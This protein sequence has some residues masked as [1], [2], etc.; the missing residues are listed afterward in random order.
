VGVTPWPA[1]AKGGGETPETLARDKVREPAARTVARG[2]EWRMRAEGRGRAD[3]GRPPGC[4]GRAGIRTA[5]T[6]VACPCARV[7][8]GSR[9][10]AAWRAFGLAPWCIYRELGDGEGLSGSR[11]HQASGLSSPVGQVAVA[12]ACALVDP[13]VLRPPCPV[14]REVRLSRPCPRRVGVV[15]P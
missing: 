13:W 10:G 11:C 12:C 5:P 7:P 8:Q 6:G 2:P 9:P 3:S 15:A 4:A 1:P 14:R